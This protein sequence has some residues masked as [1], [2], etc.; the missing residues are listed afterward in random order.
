M[1][2]PIGK[3]LLRREDVLERVIFPDTLENIEAY[4]EAES[5]EER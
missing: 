4:F 3:H 1:S 5:K 2:D